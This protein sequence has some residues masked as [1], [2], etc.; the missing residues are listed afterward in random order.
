MFEGGPGVGKGTQCNLISKFFYPKIEHF[1]AGDLLRQ[2]SVGNSQ[3]NLMINHILSEGGIIPGHITV[4]LLKD[5]IIKSSANIVLIDGFPRRIDQG[6]MFERQV[7]PCRCAIF[8]DSPK[9]VLLERLIQRE[10][11]Q[12]KLGQKR[13]DDNEICREKV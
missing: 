3:H 8:L 6:I 9:D 5:A 1:S 7:T 12:Q 11:M 13:I 2:A 4:G 10:K